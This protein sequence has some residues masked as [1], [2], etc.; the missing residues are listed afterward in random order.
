MSPCK[1][2]PKVTKSIVRKKIPF[3]AFTVLVIPSNNKPL[4][5]N[6]FTGFKNY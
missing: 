2:A 1:E 6:D 4:S 5:S 3:W